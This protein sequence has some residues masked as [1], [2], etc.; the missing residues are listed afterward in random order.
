MRDS[1][2]IAVERAAATIAASKYLVAF[3]GAGISVESGIP[4]FRGSGGLWE[5]YDPSILD[6]G[7]FY[8]DPAS[9]WAAIKNL[10]YDH[11]LACAPNAAHR[12]LAGWEAENRLILTITQNIDGLHYEAGSRSVVEYH[13]SL[14][15]LICIRCGARR[16]AKETELTVLPPRCADCGGVLKPDFVFFGEGIPDGASSAASAAV[17]RC[18]CLLVIGTSGE[19]HPAASLPPAAKRN[20]ATIIELNPNPSSYT[21]RIVDVFLPLG[22]A[23]G[24]ELLDEALR[25]GLTG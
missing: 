13:G 4:P 20:G 21:S 23:N 25:V 16:A 12:V 9:A 8:S 18:D 17:G 11:W 14:R 3:T 22:A 2:D 10:F 1:L 15:D 5:T 7:T 6:I 24:M 19:V